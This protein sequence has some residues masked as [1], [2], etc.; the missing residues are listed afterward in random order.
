MYFDLGQHTREISTSSPEA[1]RWFDQGLNWIYAFNHEEAI[2]CF[3]SALQADPDCAMAHWGIGYAIGP[4]YNREWITYDL[5]E[6]AALLNRAAAAITAAKEAAAKAKPA[7]RLL[8]D[9]LSTRYPSD[10]AVEDF[11][12]WNDA[13][14]NAM[15]KVHRQHPD[16]LDICT[17]FAEAMMNRTPWLLW[18]L[19]NGC[20]AEGAD[21]NEVI[22]VMEDA[23]A[24][25]MGAWDHPGLLHLYIHVMEMSPH[26]E[27]A[28]RHGD[29]LRELMPDAGHL[30]HMPTHID[31]LCGDFQNV[32]Q[33]NDE[34]I[35]ADRKYLAHRGGDNF[36]S[37]YR[38][39]NYHFKVYG[40]LFLAQPTVALAT[41]DELLAT[42]PESVIE[43]LGDFVE[44]FVPVRQHVQIR[45][46][47]WNEIL[48]TP[49]PEDQTLYCYT[50][51]V[52]HYAR[53]VALANL[54][55]IG[56]AEKERAAFAAARPRIPESR[57]MLNNTTHDVLQV[58]EQMMSGELAYHKGDHDTAFEHLRQAVRLEDGL[59]YD[60][61]WGWMQPSRHALGALLLEQ[62]HYDEAEAV[63]RADLGL[64][65][66]LARACQ[67]PGN[68]WSLHGLHECLERRGDTVEI[69]HIRQMLDRALA[70]AEIPIR[71]SCYCRAS[72]AA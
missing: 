52:M 42:L 46:G 18:D 53:C 26:P 9:A 64:D 5:E 62:G 65:R 38:C 2:T 6:K 20:V 66:T 72:A 39:H 8:I 43:T 57:K 3:E 7:E 67:N 63:Y 37:F 47:L 1:Q 12:P 17:V 45:F 40:A 35:V 34:A 69:L 33:R 61:P 58:A 71:A 21:T 44:C 54:G 41:A 16:D 25:L 29:R 24:R 13:Y 49:M 27:R 10:P 14:A 51:A 36:Y 60:E 55:R 59:E 48:D 23:L 56:D 22:N 15:R 50:T 70:R 19:Q 11:G 31:V 32:V 30:L 28:L 68:V 4:N